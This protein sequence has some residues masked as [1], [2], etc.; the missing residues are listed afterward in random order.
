MDKIEYS[1][2]I[3]KRT[4]QTGEVPTIPPVTATTLN[5]MIPTDL[6][7]GEFFLNEVDDLLW[8][9]TENGILP[10]SLSGSTGSTGNQT[11]TEV[12]F[13]GNATN[14]YDMVVSSGDTIQYGGLPYL[15][16]TRIL[17][18]DASGNTIETSVSTGGDSL[19]TSGSTLGSRTSVDS[20]NTNT[21]QFSFISGSGNT[22]NLPFAF[23]AGKDNNVDGFLPGSGS[24]GFISGTN[25]TLNGQESF[26]LGN[27]N[28]ISGSSQ[29]FVLGDFNNIKTV[30][31][32]Q[33]IFGEYNTVTGTTSPLG[34]GIFGNYNQSIN[35]SSSFITGRYNNIFTSNHSFISGTGNTLNNASRSAI[36]G[37]SN[38]TGNTNDM[39]YVPNLR[40][41]SATTFDSST[42]VSVDPDTNQLYKRGTPV[43]PYSTWKKISYTMPSGN[44][45]PSTS[46][47]LSGNVDTKQVLFEV[48]VDTTNWTTATRTL[49][50]EIRN[51]VNYSEDDYLFGGINVKFT[52]SGNTRNLNVIVVYNPTG[53]IT[54]ANYITNAYAYSDRGASWNYMF[55]MGFVKNNVL[56]GGNLDSSIVKVNTFPG[57]I[58]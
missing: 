5:Q 58:S 30:P 23:V 24:S 18:L 2:L 34:S 25:N 20:S 45:N 49:T 22:N 48:N 28:T 1:R 16:T 43:S 8:I 42:F 46:F 26:L 54:Y 51:L 4:A 21:G 41:V 37:G 50:F 15:D 29:M 7:I 56:Y 31:G 40:I 57:L 10:I 36:I 33:F 55:P 32:R 14:G 44:T 35:S 52:P 13:E 12:L 47:T 9:R 53:S 19:W 11:L 38:I 39:V 3:I 17:G 27:D 6:F